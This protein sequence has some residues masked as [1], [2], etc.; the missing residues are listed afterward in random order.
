[1]G[2]RDITREK[3]GPEAA[4]RAAPGRRRR[5]APRRA[6]LL[7]AAAALAAAGPAGGCR[8]GEP[9]SGPGKALQVSVEMGLADTWSWTRWNLLRVTVRNG[10]DDFR[11]SIEVQGARGVR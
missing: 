11:G 8:R 10:G 1:M 6:F 4:G 9:A 2:G 3:D 7:A 5:R